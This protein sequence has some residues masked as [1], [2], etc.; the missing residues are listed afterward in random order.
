MIV[1]P[2]S[3]KKKRRRRRPE[4]KFSSYLSFGVGGTICLGFFVVLYVLVLLCA[5][6]LLQQ[7]VP[8]EAHIERGKVLQPVMQ[9]IKNIGN[10][11]EQFQN[12]RKQQHLTD[13][14]LLRKAEEEHR[15]KRQQRQEAKKPAVVELKNPDA[16]TADDKSKRRG[17]MVLGM[18]RSGTSMLSGLL[19][20]GMGYIVGGPLIRNNFDNEKGFFERIDAVLQNDEFMNLQKVW[21]SA[22]MMSYDYNKALKMKETG[23]AKFK[24]GDRA[25]AFLNNVDS[26]PWLQKDPRM[27]ITLK[28]WLPLLN[29]EPAIVWTYRHPLEVANSLIRREPAFTLDHAIRI[30]IVYNMRGIQNMK[31][32]CVVYTTNEAVLKDALVE[33]QRVSDELTQKCNVPKPPNKLSQEMVE[34]FVDTSLQHNKKRV[35]DD[36]PVV[37]T[38]GDCQIH[39]LTTKTDP[40]KP[41]Y[42]R[43]RKLYLLAMRIFCDLESRDAYKDDYDWNAIESELNS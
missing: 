21:W 27:C 29:S 6:P 41:Q 17:F 37:E 9:N 22:N 16:V 7:S 8:E 5:S 12:F 38:K 20:D 15:R 18:H 24:E 11:K 28:T 19:V 23:Q 43:E 33:V 2:E 30:W 14:N 34:K 40:N 1:D 42:A 32:L 36:Q 31:G 26:I 25:L 10:I 3:G 39:E 13:K 35:G 4:Q